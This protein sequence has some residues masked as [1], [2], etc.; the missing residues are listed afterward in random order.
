M[1]PKKE[2]K[3]T[4]HV[5]SIVCSYSNQCSIIEEKNQLNSVNVI[6][7]CVPNSIVKMIGVQRNIRN[8]FIIFGFVSV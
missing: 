6:K 2:R 8:F 4:F 5:Y 7:F 1:K 3:K